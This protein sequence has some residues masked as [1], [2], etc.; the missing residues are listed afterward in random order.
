MAYCH[1][2]GKKI[3]GK[4]CA[5]CGTSMTKAEETVILTT[6]RT[7]TTGRK[8]IP[9]W[10]LISN[11]IISVLLSFLILQE[12]GVFPFFFDFRS[13]HLLLL[14]AV[15]SFFLA[16]YFKAK[17]YETQAVIFPMCI[18]LEF[19]LFFFLPSKEIE[20]FEQGIFI[21]FILGYAFYLLWREQK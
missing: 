11:I 18:V 10:F 6:E 19:V 5:H 16:I 21:V 1:D 15:P 20:F 13:I 9:K 17:N 3:T 7:N 2:C 8:T 14:W 12:S 4:Y